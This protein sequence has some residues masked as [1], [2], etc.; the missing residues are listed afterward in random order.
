M[1]NESESF[2]VKEALSGEETV[3][4]A[5]EIEEISKATLSLPNPDAW[6][7]MET[8]EFRLTF[9]CNE[10][11]ENCEIS[12]LSLQGKCDEWSCCTSVHLVHSEEGSISAELRRFC[13]IESLGIHDRDSVT[14]GNEDEEIF[15]EFDNSVSF[16]KG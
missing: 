8:K 11:S 7:E 5:L 16:V 1:G 9:R 4:E 14:L 15:N 12:L 2:G 6:A 13:E 10:S 3:T